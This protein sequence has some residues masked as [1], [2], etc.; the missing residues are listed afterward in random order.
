MRFIFQTPTLRVSL[1]CILICAL[2]GWSNVLWAEP[3]KQNPLRIGI[4]ISSLPWISNDPVQPQGIIIDVF[5]Y[6]FAEMDIPITLFV[7]P[8]ARLLEQLHNQKLDGALVIGGAHHAL[9]DTLTCTKPLATLP[10]GLYL[11]A[12]TNIPTQKGSEEK[13]LLG[14]LRVSHMDLRYIPKS[15]EFKTFSNSAMMLRAF[16]ADRINGV[17][18]SPLIVA[19][20]K[21]Q[22][23]L[24]LEPKLHFSHLHSYACF[25]VLTLGDSAKS[26]A[27]T[28]YQLYIAAIDKQSTK[29]P[30]ATLQAITKFDSRKPPK[31]LL[32]V[33]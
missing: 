28:F 13:L 19:H 18:S 2:I 10:F 32:E 1:F 16:K 3:V 33:E 7:Q 6:A 11:P 29:L 21:W 22:L 20:W 15:L 12:S 24:D 8:A 9:S 4:I 5:E 17:I 31:T 27:D 23:Q 25:S 30:P 26:L 14:L